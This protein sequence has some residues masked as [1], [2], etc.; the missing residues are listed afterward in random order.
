MAKKSLKS[1]DL[2]RTIKRKAFIPI[3]DD[4]YTD[5][6]LLEMMDNEMDVFLVPELMSKFQEHLVKTEEVSLV[7]G[8]YEYEIPYRA[9]GSKL[10]DVFYVENPE[11]AI[12]RQSLREMHQV[13]ASEVYAY[14]GA[15]SYSSAHNTGLNYYIKDNKIVILN[16]LP[17]DNGSLRMEFYM[18]P[19][20]MVLEK[21]A[22]KIT[23]ID[24]VNGIISMS[25]FPTAFANLP[26]DGCDF[27]KHRSPNSIVG[28][29]KGVTS[30]SSSA[31]TVTV[32]VANIPDNLI[33]GD[34]VCFPQ[35]TPIPNVPSEMH[36]MLA[37]LVVVS[38]L[39]GLDDEQAKQSAE[40]QLAKMEKSLD[41]ILTDRVEG[42]NRKIVN[43]HS[44]LGQASR[45]GRGR[46]FGSGSG[47]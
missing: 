15:Y 12:N 6:D 14:S 32:P 31:K 8:T 36:S 9:V 2:I 42:S 19:S 24:R 28:W 46:G 25:N 4:S 26:A 43:R 22:G 7:E 40:R 38:I 27:V 20:I 21:D 39:E 5:V 13:D 33:V 30:V 35:E 41:T 34:Y 47:Y 3:D 18:Q 44:T 23:N 16:E 17:S 11:E 1:N 29:D 45:G 37:Q 10:R